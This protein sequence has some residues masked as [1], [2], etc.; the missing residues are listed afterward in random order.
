M[1][2]KQKVALE[3]LPILNESNPKKKEGK[4][5]GEKTTSLIGINT[6]PPTAYLKVLK[7]NYSE[8]FGP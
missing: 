4:N 5:K 2:Y 1:L 6:Y 8:V 7:P 3:K